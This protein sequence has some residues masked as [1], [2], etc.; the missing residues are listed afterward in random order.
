MHGLA[1]G[2][3]ARV[4]PVLGAL[5]F[6]VPQVIMPF[7]A[8][9]RDRDKALPLL[10]R[11]IAEGYSAFGDGVEDLDLQVREREEEGGQNVLECG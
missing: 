1:R 8:E 3:L 2:R 9:L 5:A 7:G 4:G 6:G 11:K 10:Q